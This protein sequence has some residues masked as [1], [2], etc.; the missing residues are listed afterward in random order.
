MI[1]IKTSY[2]EEQIKNLPEKPGVY[3]MKDENDNIIYVGK[4]IS[5][6]NRVRQYFRDSNSDAK[7]I[8][9]VKK[10]ADFEYI[11]TDNE[12]EALVLENQL[13]KKHK[14]HYNILL[15]DDKTYPYIKITNEDYPR[16]L[17]VRKVLKDGALYF[18]PYTNVFA[19]NDYL[20]AVNDIF[21][22]RN[23]NRNIEKSQK[24]NERPC[25]NYYIKKCSAPCNAKITKNNY[26]SDVND[27]IEILKGNTERVKEYLS[28]KM[29]SASR[30]LNFE[31]A[32][33]L[34]DKINSLDNLFDKQKI[35]SSDTEKNQDYIA[36]SHDETNIVFTVFFVRNGKVSGQESFYFDLHFEEIDDAFNSFLI[37]YYFAKEALPEEIV[38]EKPLTDS[39][40]LQEYL[41]NKKGKKVKIIVPQK[42]ERKEMLEFAKKNAYEQFKIK[43]I[44]ELNKKSKFEICLKQLSDMLNI[45]KISI[46]ES[47]DISNI[48]GT[49]SVGV[50]VVYKDGKKSP[51]D[52]RRYRIKTLDGKSDDYKAMSEVLERRFKDPVLPDLIL[53]DGGKGHVSTI[54]ALMKQMNIEVPIYG[55]YKDDNHRTEGICSEKDVFT[56]DKKSQLF[57]FLTE[58]QDETH[59]FAIDYH[60]SM[61]NKNMIKSELD[62]IKGIG[63]KR[64]M[65]IFNKFGSIENIKNSTVEEI[66]NIPGFNKK[67]AEQILNYFKEK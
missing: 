8:A 58:I 63:Q 17:K 32:A 7:V 46:I 3:I 24:T 45:D 51:K 2:I 49:D 57:R 4:A 5:L 42:G 30:N 16:I 41:N 34:R 13:I 39:S 15:K 22:L 27:A 55:L 21:K 66:S 33:K 40:L 12:L 38:I 65:A 64:K 62:D 1:F 31:E 18:G 10:I 9:M 28:E 50:K 20:E 35:V 56:V 11:V 53:L 60:R 43:A 61:R 59:R 26:Q 67:I 48:Q 14:P 54:K 37:Q 52:Y 25:L 6:K 23:C 44:R 47:Y 29:Y 19:L 36:L